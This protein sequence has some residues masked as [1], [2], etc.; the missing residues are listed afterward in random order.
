MGATLADGGVNPITGERAIGAGSCRRVLAVLATSG[1]YERS[2]DWLYDVGL[3]GKSGVSGGLV[4]VSPGKGGVGTWSP[5]LD[6]AGNSV[7]G[8]RITRY[9]SEGAGPQPLRLGAVPGGSHTAFTLT[10]M[11]EG[12]WAPSGPALPPPGLPP[13][14][15]VAGRGGGPSEPAGARVGPGRRNENVLQFWAAAA[16]TWQG[17]PSAREAAPRCSSK[18]A[19][20]SSS[21]APSCAAT[22]PIC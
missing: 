16:L 1:L 20:N 13:E 14:P 6:E 10:G 22:T 17:P 7:R 5:P 19:P 9:L 11:A 3:P 12:L 15:V 21:C 4:T 18:R 8:Q 2:G